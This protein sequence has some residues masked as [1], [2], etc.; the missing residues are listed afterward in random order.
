MNFRPNIVAAIVLLAICLQA[1]QTGHNESPNSDGDNPAGE[2][3]PTDG[4]EEAD[5]GRIVGV[6]LIPIQDPQES[7]CRPDGNFL[8]V[9]VYNPSNHP[10]PAMDAIVEFYIHEGDD[11]VIRERVRE[12]LD[13]IPRRESADVR[14]AFPAACFRPDCSFSIEVDDPVFT[15]PRAG[16]SCVG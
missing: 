8:V 9:R 3:I 2:G 11:R 15:N 6:K 7:F 16:G 14:F 5:R 1:C 4:H 12:E 10:T 13:S